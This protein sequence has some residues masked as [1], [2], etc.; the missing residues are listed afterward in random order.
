MIFS[1][2]GYTCTDYITEWIKCGNFEEFP[3]RSVCKIPERFK[4]F[5]FFKTFKPQIK[6]RAVRPRVDFD[7]LTITNTPLATEMRKNQEGKLNEKKLNLCNATPVRCKN[8][9]LYYCVL[10]FVD[11]ETNKNSF[12]KLQIQEIKSSKMNSSDLNLLPFFLS[13]SWG[14]IGTSC[15]SSK[16]EYF[17]SLH[18]ASAEF[19]KKYQE[20]TGNDWTNRDN[21]VR[22]PG[23]FSPVEVIHSLTSLNANVPQVAKLVKTLFDITS[24][25]VFSL[26][27]IP[28]GKLSY[29]QYIDAK[30]ILD[31][32]DKALKERSSQQ[33]LIGLSNRF[34]T[35]FPHNFGL[36]HVPVLDTNSKLNFKILST[37]HNLTYEKDN[38]V[39]RYIQLKADIEHLN[40]LTAEFDNIKTY[41]ER[42][43]AHGYKIKI[44][45][46]FKV[47][48]YGEEK[49]YAPFKKFS[50]RFLLWHGSPTTSFAS[51]ISNGL[52]ITEMKNG[53]MFGRG[54]YFADIVSKSANYCKES[55]N[56]GLLALCEVA[57]GN[58]YK[59]CNAESLIRPPYRY[60]S[61]KG[62]G[63]FQPDLVKSL[64]RH[65]GVIIPFGE[66][67]DFSK[68][69]VFYQNRSALK[70]NEY[71]VYNEAQIKLEYLVRF[72]KN[73]DG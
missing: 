5:R 67:E 39:S 26:K 63:Q 72:T 29:R 25:F 37:T 18:L 19:E 53:S 23:K 44:L 27:D 58:I 13:S 46:V 66:A 41:S 73:V 65:D 48:R 64:K 17:E 49:R 50:N 2:F 56:S 40:P 1:K 7:M 60:D 15:F 54:I 71:V 4:A 12:Y 30:K 14:R 45:E 8:D 59:T 31:E 70:F 35:L 43:S 32:L 22:V 6:D 3:R 24:S 38:F 11:I 55:N 69:H 33:V 16:I 52:K 34:F 36:A 21:F 61:V 20:K 10:V 57:L 28:V 68:T 42:T 47:R 51:I 9:I 62:L